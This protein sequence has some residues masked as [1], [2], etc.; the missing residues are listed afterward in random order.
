MTTLEF[1]VTL[2]FYKT[3]ASMFEGFANVW[4]PV[5][6]AWDLRDEIRRVR[7]AGEPILL[8]RDGRGDP[9]ACLDRSSSS[10]P[11]VITLEARLPAREALG[12]IWIFTGRET[13]A[14]GPAL[15]AID[16]V[17]PLVVHGETWSAPFARVLEALLDPANL[18]FTWAQG[19]P[20]EP[21]L[22][23]RAPG[24][25][26]LFLPTNVPEKRTLLYCFPETGATTRVLFCATRAPGED[27]M[28]SWITEYFAATDLARERASKAAAIGADEGLTTTR[29]FLEHMV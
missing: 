21:M 11:E 20:E 23:F 6:P 2:A 18:P 8:F 25:V 12:L 26:E 22:A 5:L 17:R 9:G 15:P 28:T 14:E 19:A 10:P 4:T 3:E 29:D 16:P 27:D 24:C 13:P 7:V 1:F